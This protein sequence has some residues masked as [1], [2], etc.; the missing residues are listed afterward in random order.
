MSDRALESVLALQAMYRFYP[1]IV[2]RLRA[3][4]RLYEVLGYCP[5]ADAPL[6]ARV[7]V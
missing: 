1:L 4:L 6:W 2:Q 7:R 5:L 3:R